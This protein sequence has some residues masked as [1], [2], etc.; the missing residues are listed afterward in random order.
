MIWFYYYYKIIINVGCKDQYIAKIILL[1]NLH[2][3]SVIKY[4]LL[5]GRKDIPGV[6][7]S[8]ES[9]HSHHKSYKENNGVKNTT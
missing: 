1:Q 6:D 8:N 9:I 2:T 7:I 5:T 3:K 4:V